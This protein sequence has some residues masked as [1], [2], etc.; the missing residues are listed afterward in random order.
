MASVPDSGCVTG[1]WRRRWR[2]RWGWRGGPHK[3]G[4]HADTAAGSSKQSEQTP[5]AQTRKKHSPTD[6]L[7]KAAPSYLQCHPSSRS[8]CPRSR[9]GSRRSHPWMVEAPQPGLRQ[10]TPQARSESYIQRHQCGSLSCSPPFPCC[11]SASSPNLPPTL[12]YPYLL[13]SRP[14]S[15]SPPRPICQPPPPPCPPP[16]ISRAAATGERR[17]PLGYDRM[18]D[19]APNHWLS[20]IKDYSGTYH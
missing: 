2:W 7:D 16:R 11:L 20:G 17:A 9:G 5:R 1:R 8:G 12:S 13:P 15:L 14:F 6:T 10:L 3:A 18:E 4:Q 19:P